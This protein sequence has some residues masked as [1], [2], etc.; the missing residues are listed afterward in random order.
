MSK[1]FTVIHWH[2]QETPG[3]FCQEKVSFQGFS[4]AFSDLALCPFSRCSQ[5][6]AQPGPGVHLG[7][8]RPCLCHYLCEYVTPRFLGEEEAPD[9]LGVRLCSGHAFFSVGQ[10][11][12][13]PWYQFSPM[14]RN[15]K[16]GAIDSG[17]YFNLHSA[18]SVSFLQVNLVFF[19]LVL[20]ILK[21]KLSSLN[22]EVSTI[23][24]IR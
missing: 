12:F 1:A 19:L 16:L 4:W 13:F 8:P 21:K 24:N 3:K 18:W 17:H 9:I 10:L 20:W 14:C 22:T 11:D 6:L 5:L 7:F 2:S 23:Q 15:Q